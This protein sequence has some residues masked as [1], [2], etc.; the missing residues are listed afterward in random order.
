MCL[1]TPYAEFLASNPW[2]MSPAC[3]LA[4]VGWQVR[5]LDDNPPTMLQ[6]EYAFEVAE[7]LQSHSVVGRV[8]ANDG[9][10]LPENRA[11]HYLLRPTSLPEA[12]V[13]ASSTLPSSYSSSF[14]TSSKSAANA[15]LHFFTVD[16]SAVV[17]FFVVDV[18]TYC[19]PGTHLQ[20]SATSL[21]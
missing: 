13:V 1:V 18:S 19:V 14:S 10:S 20:I 5:D 7:G 4:C 21:Q 2:V 16:R 11:I 8:E 9:D 3:K 15:A 6:R 12:D 17:L